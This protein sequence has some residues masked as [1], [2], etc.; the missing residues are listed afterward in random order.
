MKR[1]LE[2][3][4]SKKDDVKTNNNIQILNNKIDVEKEIELLC[5]VFEDDD[6]DE[7][8]INIDIK[9]KE[10]NIEKKNMNGKDSRK[11]R[12]INKSINT[13]IDK[14][15]D[16]FMYKNIKS[17]IL[18]VNNNNINANIYKWKEQ[19]LNELDYIEVLERENELIKLLESNLVI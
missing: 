14:I 4:H 3:E 16:E 7:I 2:E 12:Y 1:Q 11:Y 6:I 9:S 18:K 8:I 10:I 15:D 19:L 13:L 17:F 5:D